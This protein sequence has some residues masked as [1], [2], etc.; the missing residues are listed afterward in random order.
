MKGPEISVSSVTEPKPGAMQRYRDEQ[1]ERSPNTF[2][3]GVSGNNR[4][5][6]KTGQ[7]VQNLK[8]PGSGQGA[9]GT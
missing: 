6:V 2:H 7:G 1:A 5:E 4:E 8:G 3:K 9:E